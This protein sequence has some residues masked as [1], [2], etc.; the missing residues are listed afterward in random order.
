M[1]VQWGSEI[2][3]F[4][5][6]K[7]LKSGLF[8]GRISNGLVFKWSGFSYQPFEIRKF[9]SGFQM[10]GLPDFRS[11]LKSRPFA[12]Q[13]VLDHSKSRLGQISDPHCIYYHLMA[14]LKGNSPN[15][16]DLKNSMEL[17]TYIFMVNKI[18]LY[19]NHLNTK[20]LNTGP[21]DNRTPIYHS[22]TRLVRFSDGY[23]III[24]SEISL[25]DIFGFF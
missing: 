17:R 12:T 8:E 6:R 10:V 13:P 20:H 11:H 23:C 14:P 18:P 1:S 9:L 4:E 5:I 16:T 2:R 25:C 19:I 24:M 7:H 22:N 15:H 3:P 21:F